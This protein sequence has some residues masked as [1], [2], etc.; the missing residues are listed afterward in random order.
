MTIESDALRDDLLAWIKSPPIG[1][2]EYSS[3]PIIQRRLG[4]MLARAGAKSSPHPQRKLVVNSIQ[5]SFPDK[6]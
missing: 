4:I 5:T 2:P 6:P 1:L 3:D